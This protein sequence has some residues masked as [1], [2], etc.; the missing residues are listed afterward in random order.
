LN[1]FKYEST[2]EIQGKGCQRNFTD[3]IALLIIRLMLSDRLIVGG[4][5]NVEYRKVMSDSLSDAHALILTMTKFLLRVQSSSL[6][7]NSAI[8]I[9]NR[10]RAG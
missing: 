9:V 6:L 3:F 8:G 2:N 7:L 1:E 10:L 4:Q 5:K